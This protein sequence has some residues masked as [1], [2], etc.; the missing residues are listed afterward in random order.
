MK[1]AQGNFGTQ[2][3]AVIV[4][5]D[6]PAGGN[7]TAARTARPVAPIGNIGG[8]EIGGQINGFSR[9]DLMKKAGMKWVKVQSYGGDESGRIASFHNSGFKILLSVLGDHGKVMDPRLSRRIRARTGHHGR[10]GR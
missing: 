10:S 7:V 2:M 9:P 3:S 5:G 8:F 4:A 1:S 6:P